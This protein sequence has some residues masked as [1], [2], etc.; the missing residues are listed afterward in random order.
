MSAPEIAKLKRGDL[1]LV[2]SQERSAHGLFLVLAVGKAWFEVVPADSPGSNQ[3]SRLQT[4][5][6]TTHIAG[7]AGLALPA[8]SA[9]DLDTPPQS[10]VQAATAPVEEL[11]APTFVLIRVTKPQQSYRLDFRARESVEYKPIAHDHDRYG[12]ATGDFVVEKAH[13]ALLARNEVAVELL[14]DPVGTAV[15][16]VAR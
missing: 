12:Q 15:V 16:K 6:I 5:D 2:D 10:G 4:S 1:V 3:R 8:A 14:E 13:A 7:G 11:P 9:W